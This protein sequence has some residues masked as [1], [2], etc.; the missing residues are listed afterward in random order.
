[1]ERLGIRYP[2]AL[3]HLFSLSFVSSVLATGLLISSSPLR[4]FLWAQPLFFSHARL[5]LFLDSNLGFTVCGR[6]CEALRD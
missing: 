2:E 3:L 4:G 1:M 6:R 5:V